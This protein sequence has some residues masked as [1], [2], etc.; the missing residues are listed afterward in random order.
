MFLKF[1]DDRTRPYVSLV[2]R[3]QKRPYVSQVYRR[4]DEAVCFFS[5]PTAGRGRLILKFS[6]GKTRPYVS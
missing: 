2:F 3:Q 5:F 1:T 6:D 4:Q